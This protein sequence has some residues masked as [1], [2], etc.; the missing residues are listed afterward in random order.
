MVTLTLVCQYPDDAAT[1]SVSYGFE[2]ARSAEMA[3]DAV[4]RLVAAGGLFYLAPVDQLGRMPFHA[5]T[6]AAILL[7]PLGPKVDPN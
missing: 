6:V 5:S 2:D 3:R 1:T 4:L 7:F